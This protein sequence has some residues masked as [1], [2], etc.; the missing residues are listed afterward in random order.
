MSRKF[1]ALGA[2]SLLL[3]FAAGCRQDMHNQPK[4]LPLRPT[5]FFGDGRSERPLV[6]GTV[7]R[8]QLREDDL[9]YTGEIDGK[10]ANEFPYPVTAA[11]VARG[12]QRFDIFCSPCHGTTGLG[13]GMVVQRGYRRPP[14]YFE[15]RLMNAPLGHFYDV[16]TNGFGAM[17]DYR[18]QVP[19]RDRWAIVAYIKALQLSESATLD[20]VPPAERAKLQAQNASGGQN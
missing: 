11:M 9:L 1:L 6:K 15:A 17:P 8:G 12:R 5:N 10:V 3:L 2:C 16:I 19:V 18:D 4:Y 14:S 13:N 7:A 20:D